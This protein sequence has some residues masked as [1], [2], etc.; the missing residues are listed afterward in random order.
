MVLTWGQFCALPPPPQRIFDNVWWHFRL[1]QLGMGV[2]LALSGSRWEMSPWS[3]SALMSVMPRVRN[4][5]FHTSKVDSVLS[6]ASYSGTGFSFNDTESVFSPLKCQMIAPWRL[7]PWESDQKS[8][9][10]GLTGWASLDKW[11][12]LS[13]LHFFLSV[14]WGILIFLSLG[15]C[16]H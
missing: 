2:P 5:G 10:S 11:L 9:C 12:N 16:E 13:E 15:L 1:S 7:G 8:S 4:P 3:Y 6:I 14:K